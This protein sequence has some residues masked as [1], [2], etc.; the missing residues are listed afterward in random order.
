MD[1]VEWDLQLADLHLPS[2]LHLSTSSTTFYERTPSKAALG[3]QKGDYCTCGA[4]TRGGNKDV[5]VDF[6]TL[7][8]AFPNLLGLCIREMSFQ[9]YSA[10]VHAPSLSNLHQPLYL[11]TLALEK[12][13]FAI[14]DNTQFWNL[15]EK[16]L[17]HLRIIDPR[18]GGKGKKIDLT[19]AGLSNLLDTIGTQLQTFE[20]GTLHTLDA[21]VLR[22]LPN[23]TVLR[24]LAGSQPLNPDIARELPPKLRQIHINVPKSVKA[25]QNLLDALCDPVYMPQLAEAPFLRM[26]GASLYSDAGTIRNAI[27]AM[28]LRGFR[29]DVPHLEGS[30]LYDGKPFRHGK[31]KGSLAELTGFKAPWLKHFLLQCDSPALPTVISVITIT[32]DSR[33]RR[34]RTKTCLTSVRVTQSMLSKFSQK[35][36]VLAVTA[37]NERERSWAR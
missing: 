27:Q 1:A 37:M 30:L 35:T 23:C 5:P 34:I 9:D 10:I 3:S 15:F 12:P 17:Q 28:E 8:R 26:H 19:N 32:T 13:R 6:L 2:L 29:C 22:L 18:F 4:C 25:A 36:Q 7:C 33:M 24:L 31:Y 14:T 16:H 21:S 20:C 11:T